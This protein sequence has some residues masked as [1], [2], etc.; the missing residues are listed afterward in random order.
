M[1]HKCMSL[2]IFAISSS[3]ILVLPVFI[4]KDSVTTGI[5]FVNMVQLLRSTD[6][7]LPLCR[8]CL[9]MLTPER[10]FGCNSEHG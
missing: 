6:D 9:L 8:H 3:V 2:T 10:K 7:Q 4:V 1:L 5:E